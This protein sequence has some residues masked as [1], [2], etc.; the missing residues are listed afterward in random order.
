M[1]GFEST[2]RLNIPQFEKPVD[3]TAKKV[4]GTLKAIV[5][6]KLNKSYEDLEVEKG[7][8]LSDEIYRRAADDPNGLIGRVSKAKAGQNKA[9]LAAYETV[10]AVRQTQVGN[11]LDDYQRQA[12]MPFSD[13]NDGGMFL[14]DDQKNE[15][16]NQYKQSI[17][18]LKEGIDPKLDPQLYYAVNLQGAKGLSDLAELGRSAGERKVKYDLFRETSRAIGN[19][20]TYGSTED[21]A[22][23]VEK[24]KTLNNDLGLAG[25]EEY[26]KLLPHLIVS[27]SKGQNR[28][29]DFRRALADNDGDETKAHALVANEMM[30]LLPYLN[31]YDPDAAKVVVRGFN[32]GL[33]KYNVDKRIKANIPTLEKLVDRGDPDAIIAIE[34]DIKQDALN[35][36]MALQRNFPH[37]TID[38]ADFYTE[39]GLEE[40]IDIIFQAYTARAKDKLKTKKEGREEAGILLGVET[41]EDK[42]SVSDWRYSRRHDGPR[43]GDGFY[44]GLIPEGEAKAMLARYNLGLKLGVSSDK[45]LSEKELHLV[46][47]SAAIPPELAKDIRQDILNAVAAH[48]GKM[49]AAKR[50]EIL[51]KIIR[52]RAKDVPTRYKIALRSVY[53]DTIDNM[54]ETKS[55]NPVDFEAGK[56]GK[57]FPE[58]PFPSFTGKQEEDNAL[59]QG[60]LGEMG[61]QSIDRRNI[62]GRGHSIF[63]PE[64]VDD[65]KKILDIELELPGGISRPNAK[66]IIKLLADN[67]NNLAV[68]TSMGVIKWPRNANPGETDAS[69]RKIA[70]VR[71]PRAKGYWKNMLPGI[72]ANRNVNQGEKETVTGKTKITGFNTNEIRANEGVRLYSID[73]I[74]ELPAPILA[75]DRVLD[76]MDKIRDE[77]DRTEITWHNDKTLSENSEVTLTDDQTSMFRS[78]IEDM[79]SA[80]LRRRL[81]FEGQDENGFHYSLIYVNGEKQSE[82]YLFEMNDGK[83]V[84]PKI[85]FSTSLEDGWL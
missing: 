71:N 64:E 46:T 82:R 13:E 28:L 68:L 17:D 69:N 29:D 75:D 25:K 48:G 3:N 30:T 24:L 11:F 1:A 51:D 10:N 9:F 26:D 85:T 70:D 27:L 73:N 67:N 53:K 61:Q 81:R 57:A 72:L 47:V 63:R 74:V 50:G 22:G 76:T 39:N 16:Y 5:D 33:V 45:L 44:P 78:V 79:G 55:R 84:S 6:K 12:V 8:E 23:L 18:A 60:Y 54:A 58:V 43:A 21:A 49:S 83:F 40:D 65:L 7:I 77:L 19:A 56:H 42:K 37:L 36:T 38:L 66:S 62:V 32:Q 41:S 15:N 34:N 31:K 59:L 2:T 14:T 80:E 35:D 4:V 52:E 20:I